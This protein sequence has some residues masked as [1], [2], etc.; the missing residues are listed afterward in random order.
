MLHHYSN[1]ALQS[2]FSN[3]IP[4]NNTCIKASKVSNCNEARK[5]LLIEF[6]IENSLSQIAILEEMA[7]EFL[8]LFF[9]F[10]P[11]FHEM[12]PI[13]IPLVSVPKKCLASYNDLFSNSCLKV[14][15]NLSNSA[16]LAL[17][18]TGV[19][20][21]FMINLSKHCFDI[22]IDCKN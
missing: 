6:C 2:I 1:V 9:I 14:S 7:S 10:W 15:T 8:F 12:R 19:N 5:W 13:D 21:I 22:V 16:L 4:H 3:F 20:P 18:S 17:H 11:K